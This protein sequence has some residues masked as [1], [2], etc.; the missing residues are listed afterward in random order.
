MPVIRKSRRVIMKKCHDT[1]RQAVKHIINNKSRGLRQIVRVLRSVTVDPGDKNRTFLRDPIPAPPKIMFIDE[2]PRLLFTSH[3]LPASTSNGYYMD[4]NVPIPADVL[5]DICAKDAGSF[6]P[7]DNVIILSP[8]LSLSEMISTIV[9]ELEHYIT[10][11][12]HLA[13]KRSTDRR[14]ALELFHRYYCN[15][16]NSLFKEELVD[17]PELSLDDVDEIIAKIDY[18]WRESFDEYGETLKQYATD[19]LMHGYFMRQ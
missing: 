5:N 9:H 14:T 2:M 10:E 6:I 7:Q 8:E 12:K 3:Y 11:T 4:S 1:Y 15:E 16:I 13:H 18:N 19:H 17:K